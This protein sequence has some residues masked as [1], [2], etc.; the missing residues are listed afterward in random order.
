MKDFLLDLMNEGV[1]I[2]L[3]MVGNDYTYQNVKILNVFSDS[4]LVKDDENN[5]Y[6]L[7]PFNAICSVYYY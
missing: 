5:L 2:N 7:V 4:L 6:A 3:E 1:K